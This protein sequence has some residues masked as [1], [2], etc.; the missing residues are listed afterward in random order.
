MSKDQFGLIK[1]VCTEEFVAE[2]EEKGLYNKPIETTARTLKDYLCINPKESDER[3]VS[4]DELIKI[5]DFLDIKQYVAD[6]DEIPK[7]V[8]GIFYQ[9]IS[10]SGDIAKIIIIRKNLK[11]A[12]AKFRFA[13]ELGHFILGHSPQPYHEAIENFE[14]FRQYL[15][16]EYYANYFAASLLMDKEQFKTAMDTVPYDIE[17]LSELF[18]VSYEQAA[19]RF[20]TLSDDPLHF[21]KVDSNGKISKRFSN[22]EKPS[23]WPQLNVMCKQWGAMKA[24]DVEPESTHY[25]VS[26]IADSGPDEYSKFICSSRVIEKENGCKFSVTLGAPLTEDQKFVEDYKILKPVKACSISCPERPNC[27]YQFCPPPKE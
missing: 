9:L 26:E 2:N 8:F 6:E 13:H 10:K 14:D 20:V 16:N 27:P 12:T 17:N 24:F 3:A 7:G 25:Q 4:I 11:A 18:K 22:L 15:R 1:K 23:N 19:H 21:L 5:A